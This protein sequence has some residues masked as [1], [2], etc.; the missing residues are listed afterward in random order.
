MLFWWLLK[1]NNYWKWLTLAKDNFLPSLSPG[2][3]HKCFQLF[4]NCQTTYLSLCPSS[5]NLSVCHLISQSG[6]QLSRQ[7]ILTSEVGG[8]QFSPSFSCVH[9]TDG[10]NN[11]NN[12]VKDFSGQMISTCS[13][14]DHLTSKS[15]E[16][17]ISPHSITCL[18]HIKATRIK[19]MI[20]N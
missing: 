9:L 13:C 19:K 10:E 11:I 18:S 20:S 3:A 2:P 6:K 4:I 17:L 5:V 1:K 12:V 14:F 16:H 8:P 7:L 15:T